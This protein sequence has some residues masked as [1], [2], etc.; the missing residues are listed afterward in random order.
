MGGGASG[1][2]ACVVGGCG[3]GL[4]LCSNKAP[5]PAGDRCAP[6]GGGVDVCRPGFDGGTHIPDGGFNFPD[7]GFNFP[8][9]GFNF[10]DAASD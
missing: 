10:P 7:G 9:S 2:T 8:D 4:Q 5:C 6:I 1:S 3:T